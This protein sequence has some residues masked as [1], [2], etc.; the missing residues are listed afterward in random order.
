MTLTSLNDRHYNSYIETTR[1]EALSFA[2]QV[3]FGDGPQIDAFC[4]VRVS[5]NNTIFDN[6]EIQG[7]KSNNWVETN[8]GGASTAHVANNSA[9][10]F[11][12]TAANGDKNTRSSKR[13]VTYTPGTSLLILCSGV[14]GAG[15]VNSYQR[16]GF[17]NAENGVFFE[18]KDG[19]MG[20]VIRSYTGGSANNNRIARS[21]WNIDTMDGNGPS[22]I[23]LDF[24]KAQ[25][26]MFDLEWLGVGRVRCGLVHKGK[27]HYCHEFYHNNQISTVYMSSP[28]LP[29]T[30][31]TENYGA[32][33]ALT[34]FLQICSSASVEG[35][36]TRS[37]LPNTINRG[38]TPVS[39]TSTTAVPVISL[40]IQT[41]YVG[42]GM[43][44]PM[45]IE[46]ITQ[47][48]KDHLF[49]IIYNPTLSGASWVSN[50][51]IAAYDITATAVTGGTKI[52]SIYTASSLRS[53]I[54]AFTDEDTAAI[55]SGGL[56]GTS[57][58]LT[59]VARSLTGVTTGS[60]CAGI[61][62]DEIY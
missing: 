54:E 11:T 57:D 20:V 10:R 28:I 25:I 44:R 27:I 39:T 61:D 13:L 45:A 40:R 62:Y 49:E 5:E 59:V 42:R 17:F 36:P 32:S 47:G 35:V 8:T 34:D 6:Y 48:T 2:Q 4:R 22:G 50:S 33:T 1:D 60:V 3:T 7:K 30:Y 29:I 41:G 9:V 24:T 26:F 21:S 16:I 52:G 19:V 31:E 14:M 12:M 37:A 15:A 38:I 23:N 18:Q 53:A 55:I 58:I 43:L 51:V 46:A 56:N